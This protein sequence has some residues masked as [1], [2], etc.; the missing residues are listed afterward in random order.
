MK[1]PFNHTAEILC[2]LQ[3][4]LLEALSELVLSVA[5]QRPLQIKAYLTSTPGKWYTV[6]T[7]KIILCIIW[8]LLCYTTL[9]LSK[10][11][12]LQ[13]IMDHILK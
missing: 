11:T 12:I 1:F 3:R 10:Y 6:Y 7:V 8:E 5:S 13:S 9:P 4:S 2:D